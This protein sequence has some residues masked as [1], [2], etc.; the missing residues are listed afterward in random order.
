MSEPGLGAGGT[1]FTAG[2]GYARRLPFSVLPQRMREYAID[3]ATRKQVPVDLPALTMLGIIGSVAGPRMVIRRDHDW[4]QPLNTYIACAL[5]SSAGK[6]PV[7]EELRKGLHAAEYHLIEKHQEQVAA[8]I[9]AMRQEVEDK[10]RLANQPSTS[11]DEREILRE[12]AKRLEAEAEDLAANPPPDPELVYDGDLT[13]EALGSAMA[14]NGGS[15]PVI[16][17]EGT[18]LRNLGGQYSGGKTGNLG[19][20]L[21]GY[22]CRHYQPRRINRATKPIRRA[23]LSLVLSPQPSIIAE[24]KNNNTMNELG[25]I[26]RF[27]VCVPGDLIGERE[28]RPATFIDD[29]PEGDQSRAHRRWWSDLLKSIAAYDVIDGDEEDATVIDLTREAFKLHYDYAE[30]LER[31]CRHGGDLR[32]V[33]SWAM[34][35]AGRTLRVSGLLH[36]GAGLTP[37]DRVSGEVMESAISFSRWSTEHF[38]HA[39]NVVGLSE[40]AD[41][42]AEYVDNKP[43]RF[44]ARSELVANVFHG[45]A[46]QSQ[47]TAYLK[48]LVGTGKWELAKGEAERGRPP[49]IVRRKAA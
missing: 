3:L 47:V 34:K 4:I 28:G 35:E 7:Y 18:F 20:V 49:V 43:L 13:V 16:D 6:S 25:F 46:G 44:A 32:D 15:G 12:Q 41:R 2:H 37:D 42:I 14:D 31:R 36:L 29:A 27:I 10:R 30:E 24:M 48:E 1:P 8:R 33:R 9:A 38:L 19:L 23:V 40:G 22:D 39:G 11:L 21:V 26:N 17:D 45:H 5:E